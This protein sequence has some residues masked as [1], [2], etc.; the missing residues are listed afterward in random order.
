MNKNLLPFICLLTPAMSSCNL[1]Q[2]VDDNNKMKPNVILFLIDDF[3]YGDISFEENTQ[4]KTPNIDR[5]ANGGSMFTRFYQSAGASAP[6][7]AS[8]L[9]GRYHLETGVWDVHAG[10]DF[11]RRDETT[12]ADVLKKSGYTT[13]AFGKWHSGK[14]YS[15]FSWSRGFDTG[16]HPVLYKFLESRLISNNKLVNTDGPVEDVLGDAVVSFINENSDKPF[17]AYVPVQ[18]VHEPYNCPDELFQKYKSMGYSDHVARLYG[19]IEL[20][21]RNIGKVLDAVEKNDLAENTMIMFLSDDGPSPGFDLE[22]SNRRMNENE[23]EERSRAWKRV[24]KGGKASIYEGGEITPFYVMWKNKIPAGKE[25]SNLSGIIDIFPTILDACG[26][27]VPRD[28]LPLAGKSLWPVIQGK[29]I[30]DWD[31]RFYFDN[32]NFYLIPRAEINTEH[33]RVRQISVHHQNLKL[34][35]FDSYYGG[36]DTVYYELYDLDKDPLEKKNIANNE[37]EVTENL[38]IEIEKWFNAVLKGGRA[39]GQAVYEVGQWEERG[40]PVNLDGYVEIKGSGDSQEQTS[41][42]FDGWTSPGRSIS[43]NIDVAEKGQYQVELG[44][45]T[46]TENTGAKFLA[47]TKYDSA[48]IQ[49]TGKQTALSEVMHFPE[50]E[51]L[52]TIQLI[53][54]GRKNEAVERMQ[55]LIIHR[56]PGT[57]DKYVLTDPGF[58]IMSDSRLQG[59]FYL[60]NDVADFM[61]LGG[62]HD[63]LTKVRAEGTIQIIPFADN[64]DQIASVSIYRDFK[65]VAE[66][67]ESPF[68]YDLACEKDEKF[69]LNVE[70][71]S[72]TGVKNSARAYLKIE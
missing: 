19:M 72:K 44:Y 34:I 64:P 17:F 66:I 60:K 37:P 45:S 13:G 10:R 43:F 65:R 5:I 24:L 51:Q 52:L 18:S 4:I 26:I 46:K 42:T 40:S 32:T 21:D 69:T 68:I 36:Q 3:G 49:I 30:K 27:E 63:E 6:T 29:S 33:P 7:R 62:R 11:I 71:T 35:R 55:R 54:A 39:Y 56:I 8:L 50:G 48:R 38:G 25:F 23:K 59:M 47:Y 2:N 9:T 58:K 28:N 15:Y 16:I 12:I 41:F 67:R 20:F 53:D 57:E 14:T 22:Y 1:N 61:F 31:N 70:F